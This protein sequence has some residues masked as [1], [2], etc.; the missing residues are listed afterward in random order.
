MVDFFFKV[1][2]TIFSNLFRACRSTHNKYMGRDCHFDIRTSDSSLFEK[3]GK[4][5]FDISVVVDPHT[6]DTI[7]FWRS[8]TKLVAKT[9][10]LVCLL[11]PVFLLNESYLFIGS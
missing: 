6:T 11:T 4:L 10:H 3:L 9:S 1:I 7:P 5:P 8:I 2:A